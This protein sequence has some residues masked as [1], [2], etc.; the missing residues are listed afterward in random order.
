MKIS[1]FSNLELGP[2]E[3]IN[4]KVEDKSINTKE[5][6]SR[7]CVNCSKILTGESMAINLRSVDSSKL[8]AGI[9][10]CALCVLKKNIKRYVKKKQIKILVIVVVVVVV[11]THNCYNKKVKP[12]VGV[13]MEEIE[14]SI[15]S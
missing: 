9:K 7:K 6:D 11:V 13:M 8:I 4:I 3:T 5:L 12:W 2:L 1:Y 15:H 14:D 10:E